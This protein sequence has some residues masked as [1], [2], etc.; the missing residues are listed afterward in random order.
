VVVFAL[1]EAVDDGAL[2]DATV[3]EEDDLALGGVETAAEFGT[4]HN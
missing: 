2:A 1:D 4:M 3:A